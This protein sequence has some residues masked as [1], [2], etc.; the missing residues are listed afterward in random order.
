MLRTIRALVG[1]GS[2]RVMYECRRCGAGLDGPGDCCPDCGAA[3]VAR[4]VL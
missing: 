4:F 2:E 1:G 3:E